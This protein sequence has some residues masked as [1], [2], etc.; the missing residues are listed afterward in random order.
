VY[1][2]FKFVSLF[3]KENLNS[4]Y[5]NVVG[6][7]FFMKIHHILL[8][9]IIAGLTSCGQRRIDSRKLTIE[10][11]DTTESELDIFP[12][13]YKNRL[14]DELNL[15]R[16]EQ[17]VDSFELRFDTRIGVLKCGFGQLLVLKKQNKEWTCLE[18]Q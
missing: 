16:L 3:L 10:I 11:P 8:V 15:Q 6:N 12:Y 13:L 5:T 7:A 17:G 14:V 4:A 2:P 18:Y 1:A 9:I